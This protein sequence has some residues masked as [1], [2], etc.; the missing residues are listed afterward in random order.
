MPCVNHPGESEQSC[1]IRREKK[2]RSVAPQRQ[3]F[4]RLVLPELHWSSDLMNRKDV[5]FRSAGEQRQC[6]P[7]GWRRGELH[8]EWHSTAYWLQLSMHTVFMILTVNATRFDFGL[9]MN[10]RED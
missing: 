3:N 1:E 9:G 7:Q 6:C 4:D 8:G 5:V 10:K 2:S